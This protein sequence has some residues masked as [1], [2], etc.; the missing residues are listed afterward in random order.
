MFPDAE[1]LQV[2]CALQHTLKSTDKFIVAKPELQR[3]QWLESTLRPSL[4][5]ETCRT[6]LQNREY[7]PAMSAGVLQVP[8]AKP[9]N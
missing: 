3:P 9:L 7:L 1:D 2:C 5:L 6:S 8:K 4:A